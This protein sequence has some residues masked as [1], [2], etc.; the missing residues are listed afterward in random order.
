MPTGDVLLALQAV[1][2]R[3]V[4]ATKSIRDFLFISRSVFSTI[5]KLC[6]FLMSKT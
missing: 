3:D 2:T 5:D 1:N 4:M 6:R